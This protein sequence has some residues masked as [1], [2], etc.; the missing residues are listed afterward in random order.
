MMSVNV[1]ELVRNEFYTC[2]NIEDGKCAIWWKHPD[3]EVIRHLLF[4][5][6]GDRIYLREQEELRMEQL[7]VDL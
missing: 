3:C 1:V 4:R 7:R 6:T 5:L 2:T